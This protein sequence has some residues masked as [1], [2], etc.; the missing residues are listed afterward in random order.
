ML[1][2]TES[3]RRRVLDY[4]AEAY[5]DRREAGF[6]EREIIEEFGAPYDAAQR[7]LCE[8]T[9]DYY[10][11]RPRSRSEDYDSKRRCRSRCDIERS[12]EERR[13]DT[14]YEPT[15]DRDRQARP[16]EE[17]AKPRENYTWVFVVLCIIFAIP[18]F[19][20]VMTML[21]ITVSLCVAP[22]GIVISGIGSI[23]AGIGLLFSSPIAGVFNI[24]G[25][26]I[27]L[28]IG[29]ILIPLGIKLVKLMW[30]LFNMFFRWI[31][32]LFCGKE[33]ENV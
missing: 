33:K 5:A 32:R 28:G 14:Y 4:Y 15:G 1:S 3:E 16:T 29:I 31:R 2:V 18:L 13:E 30:K 25:G 21:G 9:D 19:G 26:L 6:S 20:L 22:F 10:E 11:E 17:R 27:V 12:Y 24:A 23:I 8:N 7:I